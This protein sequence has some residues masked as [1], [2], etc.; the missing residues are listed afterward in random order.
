MFLNPEHLSRD[1]DKLEAIEK[2]TLRLV[3]QAL[4]DYKNSAWEIFQTERDAPQVIA[5][6][7]TREALERLGAPTIDLR[8]YGRVDYKRAQ[9]VLN[10][11]YAV[12]QALF[13]DSKAEKGK[14]PTVTMQMSETSMEVRQ[15]RGKKREEIR[16][17]G[18]LERIY[19]AHWQG[20]EIQ[21]L[22]TTILI[23]YAYQEPKDAPNR[24]L[25]QIDVVALP[26]GMLQ[27]RYNPNAQDS[28][29]QAGRNAPTRREPFRVRLNL[30][31]LKQKAPWRVQTILPPSEQTY[32]KEEDC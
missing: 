16:E 1:L 6:D 2:A 9:Y 21:L 7:I 4:C 28:I 19:Y 29:W 11:D 12:R 32:W 8:L 23:R 18:Q 24:S 22:T 5:E 26:N 31:R 17:P 30:K 14:P 10:K 3:F 25:L 27:D 15:Y 20:Q 13:V